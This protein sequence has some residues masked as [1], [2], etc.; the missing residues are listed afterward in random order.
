MGEVDRPSLVF[1]DLN[2]PALTPGHQSVQA[3][4]DLPNYVALLVVCRIQIGIVAKRASCRLVTW[5][6]SFMYKL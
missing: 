4:L 2:I 6:V 5:V 3:A 1:I